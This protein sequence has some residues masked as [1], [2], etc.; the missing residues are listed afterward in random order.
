AN[1]GR[2]LVQD[3]IGVGAGDRS[4][5]F[6]AA[7]LTALNAMNLSSNGQPVHYIT[8]ADGTLLIAYRGAAV[9]S[10]GDVNSSNMVFRV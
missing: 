7:T 2:T 5:V 1:G 8:N 10:I 3:A 9:G 4:V 6:T